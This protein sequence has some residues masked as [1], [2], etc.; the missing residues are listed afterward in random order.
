MLLIWGALSQ[1]V[2][3]L[4]ERRGPQA[5]GLVQATISAATVICCVSFGFW[6]TWWQAILAVTTVIVTLYFK[7]DQ[8]ITT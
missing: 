5:A 3:M 8:A 1:L 2:L 7:S 4:Y 6:Q